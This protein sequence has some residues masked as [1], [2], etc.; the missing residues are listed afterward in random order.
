MLQQRVHSLSPSSICPFHV[1]AVQYLPERSFRDGLTL[2]FLHATNMHKEQ[3][4]VVLKHF[5]AADGTGVRIRDVWCIESPNH[6]GSA[7][8]NRGLLGSDQY[9]DYWTAEEYTRA[10]F[11]FLSSTAHGVDF[12][13]RTVVGLAHSAASAPLQ[14]RPLPFAF[15][16][17]VFMDAAILPIGTRPTK[18]LCTLFGNWAKSKPHTFAGIEHARRLL[19]KTAYRGW[20]EESLDL[21][22]RHALRPV[23]ERDEGLPEGAKV[24]LCCSP[25][26]EAAYYLA[27]TADLVEEPTQIFLQLTKEDI[28]PIH[29]IIC[30]NDEYKGKGAEMKQFQIDH[31]KRMRNGSVQIIEGGHMFPQINPI[32]TAHA[33]AQ[34]LEKVQAHVHGGAVLSRL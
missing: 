29:T 13:S 34:A 30:L 7:L 3:Y 16:G 4:E 18:V 20:D 21:F 8:R 22:V 33:L 10:A 24:T 9:R 27:P 5:F 6:G 1:E 14:R 31:V 19:G 26:Q 28:T 32:G 2:I 17:L 25:R 23:D 11:A 15:A 12:R